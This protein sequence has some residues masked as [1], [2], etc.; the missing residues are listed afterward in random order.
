MPYSDLSFRALSALV[1][2]FLVNM[3]FTT[4]VSIVLGRG[5]E[6]LIL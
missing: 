6:S 5:P 1:A 4:S 3:V 2:T